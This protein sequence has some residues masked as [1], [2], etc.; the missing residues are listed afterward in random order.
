LLALRHGSDCGTV[1]FNLMNM[2]ISKPKIK[3]IIFFI[4][5]TLLVIPKTRLPIQVLLYKGVALINPIKIDNTKKTQLV[6]YNW[7]LLNKNSAI[8]NFKDTKEKVVLVN[9]WATWCP[10]CIAEMPSMQALYNDYKDKIEFV[11][12]SNE[13]QETINKFL[14][15]K[16]YNFNVY[17]PVGKAPI[18]FNVSSMPRTYLI[19]K[20]GNIIIDK[21]GTA[22]WNS[23]K[24]RATID[25]LLK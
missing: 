17:T 24:V 12:V 16:E 1:P 22:N 7:E 23:K 13:K 2:N 18:L 20:A 25:E 6:D 3:N 19:D 10:P 8:Y 14:E 5:I 4:I 21:N 11:F 9:F 15:K